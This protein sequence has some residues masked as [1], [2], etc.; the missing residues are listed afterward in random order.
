MSVLP[1]LERDLLEAARRR[2]GRSLNAATAARTAAGNRQI[3]HVRWRRF[4]LPALAAA[5]LMAS[6]TIA[7]AAGVLIPVG[8]PVKPRQP[9]NP[10]VGEGMPLPGGARLLPLRVPDPFGGPP[11]GMRVIRTTRGELCVQ[12]GRVQD[13]QLGELGVDGAFHDD[14]RFHPIPAD[15]Q[16]EYFTAASRKAARG[17]PPIGGCQLTGSATINEATG[18][19]RNAGT[20]E[21]GPRP[22]RALRDIYWGLLGPQ[23]VD[24]VY[25]AGSGARD[26]SVAP[27]LGA[28]L[29]VTPTADAGRAGYGGSSIGTP[30]M[31]PAAGVLSAIAY[32]IDGKLCERGANS[33]PYRDLRVADPCPAPH[34][35]KGSQAPP[36][37][38]HVPLHADLRV[39]D[40]VVT[41]VRVS[42]LA[43]LAVTDAR[44]YYAV[45]VPG[46][47]CNARRRG[48][49]GFSGEA[50]DRNVARGSRVSFEVSYPFAAFG[51]C[52][53]RSKTV[54]I[55]Y[56]T[57]NGGGATIVGQTVV[58]L[59]AGD[60]PGPLT[61]ERGFPTSGLLEHRSR[62]LRRDAGGR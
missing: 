25:R 58:H 33:G 57:A 50:L 8:A 34:W 56:E 49:G 18:D 48:F 4:R 30:G 7:I 47:L 35:P 27:G 55:V 9:L 23:A 2:R 1:Q 13:G 17:Y 53:A 10:N 38:L 21:S 12:V 36:V 37:D 61:P 51:G 29:I 31:M 20:G 15:A 3:A 16:A 39:H 42:F 45:R 19:D 52:A 24:V 40:H 32:R 6:A 44:H 43:P 59:P 41:G 62:S 60:R 26:V 22:P 28:Y 46:N 54:S 14:G 11:W 5:A